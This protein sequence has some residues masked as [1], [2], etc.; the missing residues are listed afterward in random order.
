MSRQHKGMVF[1]AA[2]AFMDP[3]KKAIDTV[4]LACTKAVDLLKDI[5]KYVIGILMTID[6]AITY[7]LLSVDRERGQEPSFSIFKLLVLKM[8]LYLLLFYTITY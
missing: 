7:L 2:F 6:L 1:N 5:I 8:L 3:I 4:A